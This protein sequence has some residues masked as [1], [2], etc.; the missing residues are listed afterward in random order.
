M[1]MAAAALSQ[2]QAEVA[3]SLMEA[4]SSA[5]SQALLARAHDTLGAAESATAAITGSADARPNN[6]RLQLAR[7]RIAPSAEIETLLATHPVEVA[8]YVDQRRRDAPWPALL[9]TNWLMEGLD[10]RQQILA[11]AL[12]GEAGEAELASLNDPLAQRWGV[13]LD[14]L[15]HWSGEMPYRELAAE[16]VRLQDAGLPDRV[17]SLTGLASNHP[18]AVGLQELLYACAQ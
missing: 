12:L 4:L 8:L 6:L 18:D 11:R 2:G 9:P 17:S 5:E 7:H 14:P 15:S 3:V 16:V 10:E 13:S 1:A